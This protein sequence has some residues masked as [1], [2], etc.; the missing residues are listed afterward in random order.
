MIKLFMKKQKS[1]QT[2]RLI[3]LG[4][5]MAL[6]ALT[7]VMSVGFVISP[8]AMADRFDAQINQLQGENSTIQHKQDSLSVEASSLQ[9]KINKLQQQI[10]NLQRQIDANSQKSQKLEKQIAIAQKE[11]DKQKALLGENIRA[12]YVEGQIS[13]LEML[14]SS[15]NLSDFLDKQEY[16]SA[17]E[18]KI[19]D[20]LDKITTLKAKLKAENDTLKDLITDQKNMQ[21]QLDDQQAEVN[22][23]LNLNESQRAAL[24]QQFTKNNAEITKLRTQQLIEN[25][26][27]IL[28]GMTKGV[29]GGGG[30][31]HGWAY[32]P[33]DSIIDS[34]GMFNRECVSFAA[35]K[36]ALSGRFMP[37][38]GGV[39]NANQWPGNARRSGIPMDYGGHARVGDVAISTAGYYG[40]AMYVEA[41]NSDGTVLVSQYNQF[42]DGT[43]SVNTRSAGNLYF[44]HF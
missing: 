13:T 43:Y 11:L 20:T 3:R 17:V 41:V 42:L 19:K 2:K 25:M 5:S 12:M 15:K 22:H 21:N 40:H 32:A 4:N 8:L 26:K 24:N 38:W 31:P 10:D 34:W 16:R 28:G 6:L 29:P 23:L 1:V 30:Y 18:Q 27:G 36:V 44:I 9:D 37:Y 14:A 33:Q 7:G 35:F 39:G